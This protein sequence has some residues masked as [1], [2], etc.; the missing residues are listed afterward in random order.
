MRKLSGVFIV[1]ILAVVAAACSEAD[2][3]P[4][5]PQAESAAPVVEGPPFIADVAPASALECTYKCIK[6]LP[7]NAAACEFKCVYIGKCESRCTE[8]LTCSDGFEWSETACR[9]VPVP[10]PFN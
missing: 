5:T 7:P 2:S 6:C 1:A 4:T 3:I 9:C 10:G 8:F